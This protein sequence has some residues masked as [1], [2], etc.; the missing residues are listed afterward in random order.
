MFYP[1]SLKSLFVGIKHTNVTPSRRTTIRTTCDW[2][3]VHNHDEKMDES[4]Q[5]FRD[6]ND[7][8]KLAKMCIYIQYCCH[9]NISYQ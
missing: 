1:D 3:F 8:S 6:D 9:G 7:L 4:S 2:T 5:N